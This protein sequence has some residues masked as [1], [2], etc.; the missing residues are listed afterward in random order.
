MKTVILVRHSEPIKDRVVPTEALPLSEQGHRKA[1]ALFAL[2]VFRPVKAVYSSPYRRAYSTAEKRNMPVTVDAR[3]RERELG[4]PETLN[5]AFWGRQYEDYDYKNG[6][7]E[8]LNDARERMTAAVGEI[9]SA[10]E[11]G[12]TVAVVSHAAAICAFLLNYSTVEVVDAQK[13]LRKITYNGET[14]LNGK[15]AAPSAFLLEFEDEQLHGIQYLDVEN[16]TPL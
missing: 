5:A 8:S 15:I 3:L 11:D 1:Q 9:I 10:M 4:N 2:D 12:D 13:K 14:V 7:G 6:D 16:E